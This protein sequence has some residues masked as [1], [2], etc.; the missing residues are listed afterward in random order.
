MGERATHLT[1]ARQLG[2]SGPT[3][4]LPE[5]LVR[6]DR[7]EEDAVLDLIEAAAIE[8]AVMLFW[9]DHQQLRIQTVRITVTMC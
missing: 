7:W 8:T 9:L 1:V 6:P 2:R 4:P 5:A 3:T